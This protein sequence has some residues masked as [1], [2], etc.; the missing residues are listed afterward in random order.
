MTT[1]TRPSE[2]ASFRLPATAIAGGFLGFFVSGG[3]VSLYGPM[4]PVLRRVHGVDEFTSGLPASVH[5]LIAVAGVL[6]WVWLSRRVHVGR[7]LGVGAVFLALGAAGVAFAPGMLAVLGWVLAIGAGFGVLA[8]G[9][10]TIYPR[11]TGPRS[12]TIVGWMHGSFGAGAVLLPLLLSVTGYRAAYL[13]LAVGTLL[14]V[15]LMATTSAPPIPVARDER[16]RASR[17]SLA[18]FGFLFGAYVA[19][20]A[21]TA[22]WLA[23]YLEIH[24]WSE[25]ATARW[26]SA[27]WLLFAAGRFVFAP[28]AE[29]VAPGRLVRVLL[30]TACMLLL[31]ANVGVLAP[32]ALVA[33]GLCMAP[34][35]PTAMIWLPRVLPT[36]ASGTTVAVLAAMAGATLGPFAVGA[37]GSALGIEAIPSALAVL[38]AFAA[39]VAFRTSRRVGQG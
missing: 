25:A 20:E 8:N 17:T 29:R 24:G 6:L 15:P 5:P 16:E 11:D 12:A 22:A 14:A 32:Y 3:V 34:V 37:V 35:F 28:L 26:T 13:I 19:V 9:M 27:F 7:L 4:A 23:T 33:A 21:S 10:N 31:L 38:A 1:R 2:P 39:L 18:A 36:A 30:P